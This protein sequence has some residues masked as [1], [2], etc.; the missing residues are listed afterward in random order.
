MA[1][2][3]VRRVNTGFSFCL[4]IFYG[5]SSSFTYMYQMYNCPPGTYSVFLLPLFSLL[6]HFPFLLF[7]CQC[8]VML[9][10]GTSGKEPACQCRGHKR[11]GFD[12]W[13]G[14]I[15]LQCSCL[16]KLHGQRWATVYGVSKELDKTEVTQHAQEVMRRE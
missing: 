13:V 7:M 2:L 11:C 9:P 15:P 6:L 4:G 14:R 10:G 5:W 3:L 16:E 12:P 1:F 8:K